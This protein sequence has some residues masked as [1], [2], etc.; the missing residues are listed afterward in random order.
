VEA[1]TENNMPKDQ[2]RKKENFQRNEDSSSFHFSRSFTVRQILQEEREITR[3]AWNEKIIP[4]L[5]RT[6]ILRSA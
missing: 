4:R 2:N 1:S 3:H 6:A 5:W